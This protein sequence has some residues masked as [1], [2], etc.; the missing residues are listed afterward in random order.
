MNV[1]ATIEDDRG[2]GLSRGETW[3]KQKYTDST[4]TYSE[5]G[6]PD[7]I[8]GTKYDAAHV[9]WGGDWRLPTVEECKELVEKCHW[10]WSYNNGKPGMYVIGPN[11]RTIFLPATGYCIR[12]WRTE[13]L[14]RGLYWSSGMNTEYA[15]PMSI[16]FTNADGG[17]VFVGQWSAYCG[18]A[19]RPVL[20]KN[21][22]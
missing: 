19:V 12:D 7:E 3:E 13:T 2:L 16:N 20:P 9:H 10:D 5:V 14:T 11:K 6:L 8:G 1:G 15:T 4:Y 21:K 22:K 18:L 17:G